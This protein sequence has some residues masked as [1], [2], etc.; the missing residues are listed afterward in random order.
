MT[1]L[2]TRLI[3]ALTPQ[4]LTA[5]YR[6]ELGVDPLLPI[7]AFIKAKI[8]AFV[9][10]IID[11]L[12]PTLEEHAAALAR[13][14]ETQEHSC[15]GYARIL[16]LCAEFGIDETDTLKHRLEDHDRWRRDLLNGRLV[17]A[18]PPAAPEAESFADCERFSPPEW[19]GHWR[20]WHR[21]HGCK[22]DPDAAAYT[23]KEPTK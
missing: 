4:V 15:L 19:T 10:V 17:E 14:R 5:A 9:A 1:D 21:G 23:P 7:D 22:L 13:E 12:L 3:A 6:A 20:D 2:R 8:D 16:E 11:A 18:D